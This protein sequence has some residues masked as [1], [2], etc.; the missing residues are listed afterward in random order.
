[1]Q[2]NA[3]NVKH[4]MAVVDPTTDLGSTLRRSFR[5]AKNYGNIKVTAYLCIY[6]SYE[7]TDRENLIKVEKERHKLWLEHHI[8]QIDVG[9]VEYEIVIDW[10]KDWEE[11]IGEAAK[12]INPDLV[13]KASHRTGFNPR[14]GILRRKS[15]GTKRM[16]TSD[17]RLIRSAKCPVLFVK[18]PMKD[19]PR[20]VLIGMDITTEEENYK[21]LDKEVL[22]YGKDFVAQ[23][24]DR[25]LHVVHAAENW[26]KFVH[27]PDLAKQ[28]GVDRER[29][30]VLEG[31]PAE[32]M[33]A[34]AEDIGANILVLGTLGRKGVAG[35]RIGNTAERVLER[36]QMDTLVLTV[37]EE[38]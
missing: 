28:A 14:T 24:P 9:D 16:R 29:A 31:T 19:V 11:A 25:E 17:R 5:I 1:M 23:S 12:R 21:A 2:H 27:P 32:V 22:R 6:S 38:T 10:D 30:H 15:N 8:G 37:P 4:I 18:G 3:L 33:A 7:V 36:V 34:V 20:K 13:V 35:T 26:D